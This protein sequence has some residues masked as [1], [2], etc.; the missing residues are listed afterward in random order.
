[1]SAFGGEF[2]GVVDIVAPGFFL[3]N[4]QVVLAAVCKHAARARFLGNRRA[5]VA[6]EFPTCELGLLIERV[7][8]KLF[9]P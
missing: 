9:K 8:Y 3:D 6:L 4:M 2:G 5:R 1:M 7:D